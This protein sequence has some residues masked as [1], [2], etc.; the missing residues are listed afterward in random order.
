LETAR[1]FTQS[2]NWQVE[3]PGKNEGTGQPRKKAFA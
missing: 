1:N 2:Q 3:F